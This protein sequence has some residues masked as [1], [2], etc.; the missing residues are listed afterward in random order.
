LGPDIDQGDCPDCPTQASED[1][2]LPPQAS[3]DKQLPPP[4]L[5]ATK[6]F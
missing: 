6:D 5:P 3:E 4:D 1:K 2:Q